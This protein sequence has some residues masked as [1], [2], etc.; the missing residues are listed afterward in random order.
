MVAGTAG[1]TADGTGKWQSGS[2]SGSGG[3]RGGGRGGKTKHLGNVPRLDQLGEHSSSLK[4]RILK[5]CKF[6]IETSRY[7]PYFVQFMSKMLWVIKN[8][9]KSC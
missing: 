3:D 7:L 2:C 1:T 9:V 6:L 5:F 8:P 4:K